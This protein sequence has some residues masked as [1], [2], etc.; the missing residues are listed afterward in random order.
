MEKLYPYKKESLKMLL[1]FLISSTIMEAMT[2]SFRISMMEIVEASRIVEITA[3]YATQ[4]AV[5]FSIPI[6]WFHLDL[7]VLK[8]LNYIFFSEFVKR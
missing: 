4:L 8:S 3:D 5:F 6:Y 7:N 1:L 2:A